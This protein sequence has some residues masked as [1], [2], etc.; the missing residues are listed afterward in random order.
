MSLVT[1]TDLYEVTMALSYL[2]EDMRAP[3]TFSLFVRDLPPERG[4]LVAAGLEPALDYLSRFRVG[5][6]DV[7]EFAEVLKRP[8]E[9]FAPLHGLSFDGEVRAVP[10]GRLVLS[11]EPLLEVTAPLPQAQLVEPY[12]LSLLCHQTAVASKAARCVLAAA[13]RPLVD[14]SLRRAHGPEAGMQAARLCALVGFAGTSNVAAA[15]RYG[16]PAAGTMAHSYVEAF[17]WE[18]RAFR[19]FARTH[20]G[21]VTFLVDTYDTE[22]GVA[23]AAR[24]LRDLR[25]GPGCAIRLDSGD[26]GALARRARAALDEA[27]LRDVRIIASGGLDEYA[28]AALVREGAPI[29]AYAVGTKVGTAAD[30]PYLD[31]VYKLVEYDGRPVMKL[32]SAKATAPGPKQVFRGP[33]LRDVIGLAN[34]EPPEG[35]EPLLRTVMRGGLRTE[36]P[37]PPAA[38]RARFET[39]LAA[40][41]EEARRIDAPVAPRPTVSTRLTVLTT[42][43]RHRLEARTGAGRRPG[44]KAPE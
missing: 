7:Q 28:V 41:P 15:R 38:A 24:V 14:F 4:F 1:T 33:G 25:L 44:E 13:G 27:G 10:E 8:V 20:P 3:A 19:A 31:A 16:I 35:T 17:D 40:L 23:T 29:D 18:E 34:E 36:P 12:L 11:G 22:R 42:V 9:D 21:P 2:R 39:D 37:D 6:S 43:V 26:L 32:S 5:R 30:A